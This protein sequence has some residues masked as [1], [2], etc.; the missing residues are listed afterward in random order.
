MRGIAVCR[1]V[2]RL[3]ITVALVIDDHNIWGCMGTQPSREELYAVATHVVAVGT[4]REEL[5]T[6]ATTVVGVGSVNVAGGEGMSSL[7]VVVLL[8]RDEML[9]EPL[10]FSIL[11]FLRGRVH[12]RRMHDFFFLSLVVV[13]SVQG[14]DVVCGSLTDLAVVMVVYWLTCRVLL[15]FRKNESS[16]E[17]FRDL[18]SVDC[19]CR[20]VGFGLINGS[21]SVGK[22]RVVLCC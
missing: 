20:V 8:L 17:P 4:S 15:D 13:S 21:V 19:L 12:T 18:S 16:V 9:V 1:V 6:V 22:R 2:H 10:S 11:L 5:D 7:L 14:P 3:I